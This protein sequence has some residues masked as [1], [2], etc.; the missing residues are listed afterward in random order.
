MIFAFSIYGKISFLKAYSAVVYLE[1]IPII[2]QTLGKTSIKC[3]I[4]SIAL[5]LQIF[6]AK[7]PF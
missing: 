3:S 7:Q 2:G 5:T 1:I 4:K 6:S